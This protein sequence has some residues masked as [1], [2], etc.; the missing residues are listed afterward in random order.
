M[1]AT[2]FALFSTALGDCGIAW[3]EDGNAVHGLQLPEA[4]AGATRQRMQARFP[5]ALEAVPPGPVQAVIDR[6]SAALAGAK[7]DLAD[8]ALDMAG[9][10]QFHQQVYRLARTIPP[11]QTLTYGQLAS[12]LGVPGAARAVGQ[13]L[14]HNPF[15]PVVP[16]HRVLGAD[17][18]PGGFSAGGGV[19][20]KLKMLEM[21]GARFGPQPGLFD[22]EEPGASPP[23]G[24]TGSWS[25]TS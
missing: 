10:P 22:A 17:N 13:A 14:G 11:G 20:T 16:C 15:A 25:K 3:A 4:E 12:L 2:A 6:V 18:R 9:V 24:Q 7:D 8:I 1:A 21:E 19:A 23:Q 5:D